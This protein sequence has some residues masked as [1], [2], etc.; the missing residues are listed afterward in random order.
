MHGL[1]SRVALFVLQDELEEAGDSQRLVGNVLEGQVRSHKNVVGALDGAVEDRPGQNA[2]VV[3]RRPYSPGLHRVAYAKVFLFGGLRGVR[4]LFFLVLLICRSLR[5]YPPVL[6]RASG[7]RLSPEQCQPE[8]RADAEQEDHDDPETDDQSR[9]SAACA[10]RD[11][12]GRRI[13]SGYLQGRTGNLGVGRTLAP[14]TPQKLFPGCTM[15]P[16]C[17]Q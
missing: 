7:L 2:H 1:R 10:R 4:L 11:F 8:D 6:R 17:V 12:A 3:E 9:R 16:H 14:H 13:L 5:G 15:L